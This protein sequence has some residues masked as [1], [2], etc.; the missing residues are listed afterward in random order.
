MTRKI[1]LLLSLLALALGAPGLAH[2]E[3]AGGDNTAVAVNTR[4]GS[5]LFRFAFSIK[6][7]MGEVVDN[8]NAAVSYASCDSCQTVAIA[9]QVV[10]V[11]GSPDVVTPENYAIAIND[12]CTSCDTLATAYQYVFGVGDGK[13]HFTAEGNQRIAEIRRQ[14]RQLRNSDLSIEEIQARVDT[15]ADDLY[16]V[17]RNE[18]VAA[19]KSGT[20]TATTTV[21][22]PTTTA[23][24]T[25]ETAPT[26]ETGTTTT[27]PPPTTT[28]TTPAT[29]TAPT[30]TAPTTTA[31]TTTET[32]PGETTTTP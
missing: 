17:L 24:A 5:T 3:G 8:T 19:G 2:A 31:A 27:E 9:I 15:L 6:R 20:S 1:A 22:P 30:T 23:P 11:S 32:T 25:T 18:L 26:T 12:S 10:L 28:E 21:P 14:I 4:D 7:V 16:D 13:V 29:T